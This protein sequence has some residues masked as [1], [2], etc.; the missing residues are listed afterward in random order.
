MLKSNLVKSVL[1][2]LATIV[3]AETTAERKAHIEPPYPVG[4]LQVLEQQTTYPQLAQEARMG[5]CLKLRFRVDKS[6]AI[7]NIKVIESGGDSFNASAIAAVKSVNW[8]PA[9]AGNQAVSVQFELPFKYCC[10]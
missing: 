8:M 4:G 1:F 6:G 2:S 5:C 3:F 9:R 10:Q 7:S